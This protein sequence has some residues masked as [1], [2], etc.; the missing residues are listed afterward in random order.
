[1]EQRY[2]KEVN[3]QYEADID[4]TLEEWKSMIQNREIFCE[5][6]LA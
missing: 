3:G 2:V 5:K 1:M 4:I 6:Y